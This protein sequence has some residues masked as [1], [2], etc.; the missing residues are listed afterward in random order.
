MLLSFCSDLSGNRY[1]DQLDMVQDLG[2]NVATQKLCHA[3]AT[4]NIAEMQELLR[5]GAKASAKDCEFSFS[6]FER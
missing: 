5:S 1:D 4:G 2:E 3:A 6:V